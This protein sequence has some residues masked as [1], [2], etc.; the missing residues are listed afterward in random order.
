M[1]TRR[2]MLKGAAA[3]ALALAAPATIAR[4][5]DG[6]ITVRI[7]W[8]TMPGHLI[9]VLYQK[10]ERLK[11]YGKSYTVQPISFRGSSPQISAMAANE[12]DM[13]A[14]GALVLALSVNNARIDTK[15]VADIIQ[16]GVGDYHSETFMVRSDSGINKV[17]DLKGKRIGTNAIGS[18]SDTAIRVMLDKHGLRDKRDVT[19]VEASFPNIPAMIEAQ[20]LDMGTVLQPFSDEY[21]KNGK[22]KTLFTA[23]DAVGPS[24]LVALCA[25][26]AFLAQNK[27]QLMDFFEDHVR[28]VRWFT[29]P[30][31][32]AE[33]VQIIAKFMQLPPEAL[34]YLFTTHDYYRD[35]YMIPNLRTLQTGIDLAVKMGLANRGIKVEPD[36]ADLS[37]VNE[38]KRRIEA[39]PA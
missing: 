12:I 3:G 5:G 33:A 1:T 23:K 16:D 4:A 30:K 10:P 2:A 35:P 24:E 28:S 9:P 39:S 14:F 22:F 36:H 29:D 25:N 7:G 34:Q 37:F 17:E 6:P 38:A 21:L 20:K 8:S 15:A 11:H 31:N 18:A 26:G 32:H 27:D 13:G 19:I